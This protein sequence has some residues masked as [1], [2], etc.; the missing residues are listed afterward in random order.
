MS[1]RIGHAIRFNRG[2]WYITCYITS[3][4][5]RTF[6]PLPTRNRNWTRRFFTW[7][8]LCKA[9]VGRIDAIGSDRWS[10]AAGVRDYYN[11]VCIIIVVR[12]VTCR[13]TA[14]RTGFRVTKKKKN[15]TNVPSCVKSRPRES[16]NPCQKS[17]G[18][19]ARLRARDNS[20]F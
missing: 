18:A 9:S 5:G 7:C 19:Y 16:H 4:S 17:C 3:C 2:R 1:T 8:S 15:R 14:V 10:A 13:H 20:I 12:R 11:I 6:F